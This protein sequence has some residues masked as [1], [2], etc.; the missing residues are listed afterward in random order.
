MR[1][2]A[3]VL[4]CLV[5]S[6]AVAEDPAYRHEATGLVFPTQLGGL[7][8]TGTHE[9]GDPRL[10]LSLNYRTEALMIADVYLYDGGVPDIADGTEAVVIKDQLRQSADEVEMA[11]REG[12]YAQVEDRPLPA[13][14]VGATGKRWLTKGFTLRFAAKTGLPTDPMTSYLFICGHHRHFVKVRIT[15]P[16]TI[17]DGDAQV[18]A[19]LTAL[20]AV[21]PAPQVTPAP[22]P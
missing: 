8:F 20:T 10:G 9:Y 5:A 12:L 11:R 13:P 16:S 1:H 3:T 2:V 17:Q 14:L 19:F 21:I 22:V 15:Y 7:A 18:V 6:F 4:L